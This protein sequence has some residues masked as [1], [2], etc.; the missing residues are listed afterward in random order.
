VRQLVVTITVNSKY[1]LTNIF[2]VTKHDI[3]MS[4]A[5][6]IQRAV[7]ETA[8]EMFQ[9]LFVLTRPKY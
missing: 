6:W 2:T 9:V 1:E 8:P 5:Q 7:V 3:E 4:A